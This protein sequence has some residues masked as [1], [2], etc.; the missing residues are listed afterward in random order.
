MYPQHVSKKEGVATFH[1][2]QNW[3]D[4]NL[5]SENKRKH[6]LEKENKKSDNMKEDSSLNNQTT[7]N[8][9]Q[10]G[11]RKRKHLKDN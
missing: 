2:T 10:E 5:G 8:G 9:T 11:Y 3:Y 6:V 1:N 7:E 4:L